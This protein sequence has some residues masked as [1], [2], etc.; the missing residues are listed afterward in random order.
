MKSGTSTQAQLSKPNNWRLQIKVQKQLADARQLG[1]AEG[2]DSIV[3]PVVGAEQESNYSTVFLPWGPNWDAERTERLMAK[4]DK[5]LN[6]I[7]FLS[8]GKVIPCRRPYKIH[9]CAVGTMEE[10]SI[11][12][13]LGLVNAC[14]FAHFATFWMN[15]YALA[16]WNTS[17]FSR[18][19][20]LNKFWCLHLSLLAGDCGSV[21][22]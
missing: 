13:I 19:R 9:V 15:Q 2:T 12:C 16:C 10:V 21:S 8:N 5:I 14:L 7:E 11:K 18:A 1:R 4:K 3:L 20:R 22:E 6:K 17:R